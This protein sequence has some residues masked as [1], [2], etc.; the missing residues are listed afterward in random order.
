MNLPTDV[1]FRFW[2]EKALTVDPIIA[3]ILGFELRWYAV[4]IGLG[5]ILAVLFGGRQVWQGFLQSPTLQRYSLPKWQADLDGIIDVFLGGLVCGIFGARLY[6]AA[7]QWEHFSGNPWRILHFQEGGLAIYGGLI[8]G[9]LG[10]FVVCKWRKISF[11]KLLDLC[12][13]SFL[14]GQGIGR[15][16]NFANQE[17]FG[18][19]TDLPWGMKS[20]KTAAFLLQ[21]PQEGVDPFGFVHPTFLYES[22]WCLLG[23]CLLFIVFRKAYRFH[24]QM[25][26]CY[27]V[28][29]GAGRFVL[30][31]MRTDS[32]MWGDYRVSQ[33][34]S[35]LL[36]MVSAVL[37]IAGLLR[38]RKN[39]PLFPN[40]VD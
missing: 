19:N 38:N 40:I 2:G 30:E 32:L 33:I 9:I 35:A 24:G 28:W 1:Y 13:M 10:G 27:G 22:L 39:I 14:I 21:R 36:V 16:G 4:L 15:W 3:S 8:G 26:L 20:G 31:G 34:I 5:V 18:V 11:R 37:L 25:F 17:A 6:Y 29:Y 7:F 23:F 12:G